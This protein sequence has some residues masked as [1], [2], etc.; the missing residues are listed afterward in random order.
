MGSLEELTRQARQLA[1]GGAH[2]TPEADAARQLQICNACRYCEGFCAVFPAMTRRLE[3]G[4]ADTHFLA[5]LCHNCG[6]CL[7]A[8]QYAPPHEFGVNIPRAMA[9][10]RQQSYTRYAWP[11]VLGGLY[12][13]N[14]VALAIV[15][16]ALLAWLIHAQMNPSGAAGGLFYDLL[17][18]NHLVALFAPVF[19]L[20]L[21]ALG[22]SLWRFWR[23]IHG[24]T[25]GAATT[26]GASAE[27]A[28]NALTL[29]YL[30]GGHGD[31]CNNAD[32]AFSHARRHAHHM[33]FYG[34]ALCFAA[35]S[36]ATLYHYVWGWSAPYDLPSLPKVLGALG[37]VMLCLGTASQMA[38]K[39]R[40]HP[41]QGDTQQNGSDYGLMTLL[42]VIAASGLGLWAAR[43][44]D[45]AA[46]ILSLHLGS[47]MALFVTLPYGKMVHGFYRLLALARHAVEQRQPNTLGLGGE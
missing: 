29:R 21:L 26:P 34:F 9:R 28:H 41:L 2:M 39:L 10:V 22:L 36:V 4:Q 7:H 38:L 12:Q 17:P 42:F 16:T 43:G 37:G 1:E 6:A 23:D 19:L 8:C 24:V 13:R 44:H 20:A 35:T 31:G 32:D 30:D 3:F 33:T 40:R 46:A 5:N 45:W 14:G 47:V 15:L 27:A 25:S 18:H 11:G